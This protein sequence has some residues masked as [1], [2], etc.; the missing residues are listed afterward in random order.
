M[1]LPF[2]YHPDFG[3]NLNLPRD[4]DVLF[5]GTTS[6]ARRKR[7]FP[8]L[9]KAFAEKDIR[10]RIIDGSPKSGTYYADDR[11]QLLNRTKILLNVV[12]QPWDNHIFRLLLASANGTMLLSEPVWEK[13]QWNYR[14]GV[15]FV[16]CELEMMAETARSYL[17]DETARLAI[18]NRAH[19]DIVQESGM[20]QMAGLLLDRL[21]D[22]NEP[23]SEK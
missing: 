11:T 12:K 9:E 3:R 8:I 20:T 14:P 1:V 16:S 4:N 23:V 7:I 6:D 22:L 18:V 17:N 21:K 19:A 15:H 2:G 13:S 5:L 10:L